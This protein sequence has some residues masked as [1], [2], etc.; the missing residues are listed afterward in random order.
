MGTAVQ[1]YG[2]DVRYEQEAV[3]L[4]IVKAVQDAFNAHDPEALSAHFSEQAVWTNVFGTTVVGRRQIAEFG[5]RVIA[6]M[7]D[8]YARYDIIGITPI[9]P[10]VLA[11]NILQTPTD[12]DGNE[13][14]G[15]QGAPLYVIAREPS[16]WKI[17][18]G[19][20]TFVAEPT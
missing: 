20:N 13:V 10:D 4:G 9:R 17:V 19:H 1:K 15:A 16:G 18:A 12:S 6:R 5:R 7:A 2:E 8:Q 11:V 3:A 14:E